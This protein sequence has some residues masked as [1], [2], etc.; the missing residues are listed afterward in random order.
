LI[1]NVALHSAITKV[2]E[3]QGGL[4]LNGT[5][6]FL[7]YAANVN[8]FCESTYTIRKDKEV[9]LVVKKIGLEVDAEKIKYV[10]VSLPLSRTKVQHTD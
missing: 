10:T 9:V 4:K 3:I 2:Q 6:Q 1:F 5:H 7:V 8:L